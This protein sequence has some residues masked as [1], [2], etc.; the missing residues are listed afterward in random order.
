MRTFQASQL[1]QLVLLFASQQKVTNR[2][3]KIFLSIGKRLAG[4][5]GTIWSRNKSVRRGSAHRPKPTLESH[6]QG[7]IARN[8]SLREPTEPTEH[9]VR[10]YL[11]DPYITLRA[12]EQFY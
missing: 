11:E 10:L 1:Q 2:G 8:G 4:R 5:N 9:S 3:K 6:G 12:V 7:H